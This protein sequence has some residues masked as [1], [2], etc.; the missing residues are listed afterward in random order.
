MVQPVTAKEGNQLIA[1]AR[2]KIMAELG[3]EN[4]LEK[5]RLNITSDVCMKNRGVFVTL[6]K[7]GGELKG[8]V[9][10]IEPVKPLI[11]G[12]LDNASNAAFKDSRFSPLTIEALKDIFIEVSIL[13]VP[14]KLNYKDSNDLISKLRPV[15]DGV[16]IEKRHQN[17]T[18]LPQV[19]QQLTSPET[20]LSHLCMKAGF[21]SDE[22]ENGDLTISRYQVQ[23]FE[24]NK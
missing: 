14:E 4:E 8:C 19:W 21:S 11:K 6:Y 13:T 17:A 20:F 12:V 5:T 18:F 22:W 9:G 15:I 7:K 24:E 10:N 2:Q 1:L 16:I 23:L 3:L